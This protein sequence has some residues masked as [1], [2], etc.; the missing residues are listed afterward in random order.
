M[1]EVR[2]ELTWVD[3]HNVEK[4]NMTF[5]FIDIISPFLISGSEEILGEK[6]VVYCLRIQL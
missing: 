2:T 4:N 1:G 5:R 3:K 6:S